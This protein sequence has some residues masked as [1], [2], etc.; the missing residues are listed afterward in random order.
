MRTATAKNAYDANYSI[1]LIKK[2]F[3]YLQIKRNFHLHHNCL[4]SIC[5]SWSIIFIIENGCNGAH[6]ESMQNPID[7][8]YNQFDTNK[9]F[10]C[11]FFMVEFAQFL[12]QHE[13]VV[14]VYD[15]C[16]E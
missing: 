1:Y 9:L 6:I 3:T 2:H 5:A 7:P 4:E 11:S 14:H 12:M 15:V 10:K 8:V 16:I 13:R